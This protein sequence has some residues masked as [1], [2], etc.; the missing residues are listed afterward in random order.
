MTKR[1]I[2]RYLGISTRTVERLSLPFMRVGGQNRYFPSEVERFM[3]VGP[4]D[5][6]NVIALHPTGSRGAAA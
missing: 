6:E 1:E 4:T 5:P 3:R 2:A